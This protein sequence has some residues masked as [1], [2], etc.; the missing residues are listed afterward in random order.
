MN[1]PEDFL[2]YVWQ[3]R[4]FSHTNLKT[5]DGEDLRIIHQG[6]LNKNAG[7]DFAN[8][9]MQIGETLW[10]GNVE[11]H[12]RSSDWLKHQHQN[13]LNYENVILHVVFEDD[14]KI[15]RIDGSSMPTLVLKQRIAS[16]LIDKYANL[17]LTLTDFPCM[18]QIKTVD[19]F[20]V[21]TFISRVLVERFEQKTNTV[22]ETLNALNGNW[23][24]TFYR[25][26]A[27]NFGFKVNAL[28]F[29]MLAEAIPQQIFAKHKDNAFQIEALVFGASGL[30]SGSV[31]SPYPKKLKAEFEFL[32]KKYGIKP[33]QPQLWK[34]M[35]MRPQNFPTIRLAQFAALIIKANHLFSKVMDIRDVTHL[36]SLFEELPVNDYW[37][38]HYHFKNNTT[39]VATQIGKKSI[40]NLLLNTVALFLFAYGK[41]SASPFYINRA[42]K[43]LE[44]LPAE[45]N[46]I[47]TKFVHAGLK[48]DNAFKSQ[49]V[50]QLKTQY[51]DKRKCLSCSIGIKILK[52]A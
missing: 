14:A 18:E 39:S 21:D 49:G 19:Q 48:F 11:I 20:V 23:D 45:E 3:F 43:L 26:I 44:G 33:I 40:D 9:K 34:F 24:E 38:N 41:H 16:E 8:A 22:L 15:T 2:H 51:C 28:P 42:L 31:T 6:M 10:A 47:T 27:K 52:Q 29:E 25:F 12:I 50:L 1:F 17:F 35:R 30:L 5:S 7:P 32:Q 13:D 4:S 36:R 46:A 37:K